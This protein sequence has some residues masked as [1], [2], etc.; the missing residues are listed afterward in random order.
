M[1]TLGLGEI[2]R[3]R[4]GP[5]QKKPAN[6]LALAKKK[7]PTIWPWPKKT[8]QRFGPGQKKP[9]IGPGPKKPANDLAPAP[10]QQNPPPIW[11]WPNKNPPTIWPRSSAIQR[12]GPGQ[13]TMPTN[14]PGKSNTIDLAP[15]SNLRTI[16]SRP[17]ERQRFGDD[18]APAV[19]QLPT[20][21]NKTL[22][23]LGL[24]V[25]YNI[26]YVICIHNVSCKT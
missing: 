18:L 12:L 24:S 26:L 5:G 19:K 11:P 4:F 23:G 2:T 20:R 17:A 21:R 3:Q 25:V 10:A 15:A 6:D 16:W 9:A 14:W 1:E 22:E 13:P 7:P 8:R